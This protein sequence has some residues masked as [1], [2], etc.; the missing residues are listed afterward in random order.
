[1]TEYL[2][3]SND[4]ES[5]PNDISN[6]NKF[7]MNMHQF[8]EHKFLSLIP[9]AKEDFISLT[10]SIMNKNRE[11]W[12]ESG[13]RK[14]VGK[15]LKRFKIETRNER[16]WENELFNNIGLSIT[17]KIYN[18]LSIQNTELKINETNQQ[19]VKAIYGNIDLHIFFVF[20]TNTIVCK[21][22]NTFG[23]LGLHNF[24]KSVPIFIDFTEKN[25]YLKNNTKKIC[26][27]YAYT[28][29]LTSD[30]NVYAT[31]AGENGRL[32][33]GGTDNICVPELINIQNVID[34]SCGSVHS[35]F[36][37]KDKNIYTV[38][39][40]YYNGI[41]DN[42]ILV[43]TKISLNEKII[44]ISCGTG[45]YHTLALTNKGELFS[46][47]H[48]RV[49]QLCI[50]NEYIKKT[51]THYILKNKDGEVNTPSI[52]DT[53]EDEDDE[54]DEQFENG[55]DIHTINENNEQ[56]EIQECMIVTKPIKVPLD[57]SIKRIGAAWGHSLLLSKNNKLYVCGRANE[58]QLGLNFR[59]EHREKNN[60]K[61][62]TDGRVYT[63]KI[64][65]LTKFN[66]VQTFGMN[67]EFETIVIA[68]GQLFIFGNNKPITKINT[69]NININNI[70]ITTK[71][72]D[73][74]RLL[75]SDF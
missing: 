12:K 71:V 61:L 16:N 32:G 10:K 44:S 43:P 58:Y 21:G 42:D 75:Y 23:Q 72:V 55:Y 1:M 41:G 24:I 73:I 20:E 70:N 34:I 52:S 11:E 27:G 54:H 40:K 53:P 68:D 62:N 19:R 14:E 45:G 47:G 48:N 35:C 56:S 15:L 60:L 39:S 26:T 74:T 50:S 38:G 3:F 29:F 7:I 64:I 69:D 66:N 18:I 25:P 2:K 31:G 4:K 5:L 33:N 63:D 9:N 30:G 59:K 13:I 8:L 6:L 37:T 49:G 17:D 67:G 46:W 36:L 51:T 22:N 28:F 57:M 65:C